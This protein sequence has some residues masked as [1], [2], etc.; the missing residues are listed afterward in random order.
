VHPQELPRLFEALNDEPSPY[1]KAAF[2]VALL[3]GA[4]RREILS[5]QWVD[6][7]FPQ[8]LWQVPH[9][10]ASRPHVVLLGKQIN[11]AD[12]EAFHWSDDWTYG[13]A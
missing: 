13:S 3:T 2:L 12:P 6:L 9:A 10:K 4:R 11:A 8:A 1:V 7:D 5:M